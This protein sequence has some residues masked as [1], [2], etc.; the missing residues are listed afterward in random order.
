[1]LIQTLNSNEHINT[2]N[3][4][5]LFLWHTRQ[6]PFKNPVIKIIVLK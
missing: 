3:I 5:M 6:E 2:K 1:M 4:G